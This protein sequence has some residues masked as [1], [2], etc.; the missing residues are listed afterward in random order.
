LA[1]SGDL[2]I[3]APNMYLFTIKNVMLMKK[4]FTLIAAVIAAVSVNAETLIDF[5]VSQTNGIKV[6]GTTTIDAVKINTN[7][8]SLPGI[9]FANSYV[10][11]GASNGNNAELTVEGGFKTGDK[12]VIAGA[13]NNDDNTKTAAID[14]FTLDGTTPTVLFTT[15][16][17]INGRLVDGNP[18]EE[19]FVLTADAEKLYLGR[20][21]NTGTIVT[22]LKVIRGEETPPTEP[23]AD[24]LID[25]PTVQTGIQMNSSNITI[26]AV[27][28]NTNTTSIPG[29]KFASSY[30]SEGASNGNNAELT[31]EGGFK[32]GDKIVIA[33]AFNNSDDTKKSAIDIFTLDG[34]TP[35]VL[36]TTKQFINGR[37]VADNPEE[38]TFV[39]TADADKLYLGRNGNTSTFVTTLKVTRD[40]AGIKET[41][42]VK[43]NSGAIYNLAG[44]KVDES[45][46]GVV[47]QNGKK[48]VVK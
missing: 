20:N 26:D 5:S 23:K 46:K 35:T 30:T 25:F 47:I 41:L 33:G 48:V 27:K 1:I 6:N 38:E 39:L 31:V 2:S 12:V 9:K 3:F 11:E 34:T 45:Y 32:T 13:F 10:K 17:F 44:Q 37:T 29:I 28:I 40:T 19:T 43:V 36:F 42:N 4:I 14:I 22:T 24:G 7:T 15:K 16:Q 8:T 21:G 18:E